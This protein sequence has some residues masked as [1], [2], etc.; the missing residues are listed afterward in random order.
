MARAIEDSERTRRFTMELK[1]CKQ[2][3][4]GPASGEKT[5]CRRPFLYLECRPA[6]YSGKKVPVLRKRDKAKRVP[7]LMRSQKEGKMKNRVRRRNKKE[8]S[9]T[10][11]PRPR[12]AEDTHPCRQTPFSS[13][14]ASNTRRWDRRG[15]QAGE[16][17]GRTGGHGDGRECFL[18]TSV[19]HQMGEK[20]GGEASEKR[21][22][23][24]Q[25]GD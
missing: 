12:H 8:R 25:D 18:C 24:E 22:H 21:E 11:F 5:R 15:G 2:R 1:Y 6:L 23:Y 9:R 16:G 4:G 14:C 3:T 13:R 20:S 19:G 7:F 17:E 10:P